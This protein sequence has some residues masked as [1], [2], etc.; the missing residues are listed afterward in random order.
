MMV[1]GAGA[2]VAESF[3][4]WLGWVGHTKYYKYEISVA[5]SAVLVL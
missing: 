3:F 1:I 4:D 2:G 5:A